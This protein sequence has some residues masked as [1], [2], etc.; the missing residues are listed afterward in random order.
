MVG[1]GDLAG[2]DFEST[3]NSV[4]ADGSIIVGTGISDAGNEAVLWNSAGR[5]RRLWDVML[6]QGVDPA[7]D[8][9]SSL[10]T[11]IGINGDGT[12]VTGTG[13]RNGNPEA[14]VAV[15]PEPASAPLMWLIGSCLAVVERKRRPPAP[16]PVPTLRGN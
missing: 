1:L 14:F 4:T 15:I 10:I 8:G 9:W 12:R 3:A 11:A 7:A 5:I 6:A 2:G 13:L 16:T